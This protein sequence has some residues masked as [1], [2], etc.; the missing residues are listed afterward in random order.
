MARLRLL[1]PCRERSQAPRCYSLDMDMQRS[2]QPRVR[3]QRG[4]GRVGNE[5]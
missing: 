5:G 3:S 4:Y 2:L 1:A